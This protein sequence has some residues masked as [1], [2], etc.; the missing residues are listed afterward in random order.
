MNPHIFGL[1]MTKNI[2]IIGIMIDKQGD[3]KMYEIKEIPGRGDFLALADGFNTIL[4][5][6]AI[7][8][9]T[10]Q[11][12]IAYDVSCSNKEICI[13]N[14]LVEMTKVRKE[15][16]PIL[17]CIG[18]EPSSLNTEITNRFIMKQE[19]ASI[20]TPNEDLQAIVKLAKNE[21]LAARSS[22]T[23]ISMVVWGG[24]IAT[25]GAMAVAVA[26]LLLMFTAASIY[27]AGIAAVG[28]ATT[29]A[30][31]GIFARD[32]SRNRQTTPNESLDN[33]ENFTYP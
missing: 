20:G 27:V 2:H 6:V 13:R 24:F 29:L 19:V 30:G 15:P 8:A 5:Y 4:K 14:I 25:I 16:F 18:P 31:I 10:A 21:I 22:P 7:Q 33:S 3:F 23:N 11:V 28:A 17:Y 12:V 9:A 1:K 26:V 32:A